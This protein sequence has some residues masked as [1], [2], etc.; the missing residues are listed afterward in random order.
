MADKQKTLQQPVQ[1]N[2][3][4]LHTG[5]AVTITFLPAEPGKGI[6]FR[7]TDLPDA[8]EVPADVD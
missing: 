4:G 2:G 7:R 5:A 8:P 6:V 3:V 1:L